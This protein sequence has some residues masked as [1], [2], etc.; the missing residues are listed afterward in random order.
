ML[1]TIIII[2]IINLD[3]LSSLHA[4]TTTFLVYT[5]IASCTLIASVSCDI[6]FIEFKDHLPTHA[7]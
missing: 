3:M 4:S 7:L 5:H 6:D 2:I 1:G